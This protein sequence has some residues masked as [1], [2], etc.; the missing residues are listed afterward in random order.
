MNKMI[1]LASVPMGNHGETQGM[2]AVGIDEQEMEQVDLEYDTARHTH[3]KYRS[4]AKD[5][6]ST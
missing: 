4:V 1:E 5:D 3:S 2:V 6:V